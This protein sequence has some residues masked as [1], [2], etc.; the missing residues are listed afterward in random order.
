M[1]STASNFKQ[2]IKIR[3]FVAL[4]NSCVCPVC[5]AENLGLVKFKTSCNFS[6]YHTISIFFIFVFANYTY[7]NVN[8]P[9]VSLS[10]TLQ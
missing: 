1:G 2:K 5:W 7:V 10:N 3:E 6:G 4:K 8:T 9:I